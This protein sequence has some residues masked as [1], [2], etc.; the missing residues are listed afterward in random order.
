[1][2]SLLLTLVVFLLFTC[3]VLFILRAALS[4]WPASAKFANL[5]YGLFVLIILV[6]FLSEVGLLGAPHAWRRF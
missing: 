3:L 4:L 1:M 5:V 2:L 6:V